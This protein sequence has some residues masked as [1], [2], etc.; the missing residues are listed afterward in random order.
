[1][2]KEAKK[3]E[4]KRPTHRKVGNLLGAGRKRTRPQLKGK[5]KGKLATG[6]R[7]PM[8]AAAAATK[9][10]SGDADAACDNNSGV[11]ASSGLEVRAWSKLHPLGD[12][13]SPRT[14]HTVASNGTFP[15]VLRRTA[16]DSWRLT[17][18]IPLCCL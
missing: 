17:D 7:Q 10:R 9:K 3:E 18:M 6:H 13:Y 14:G 16:E 1:M 11:A 15:L 12:A 8:V 4:R 2:W 5:H